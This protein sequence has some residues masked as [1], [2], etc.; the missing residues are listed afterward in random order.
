[1]KRIGFLLTFFIV[2]VTT[3]DA[4]TVTLTLREDLSS[5]LPTETAFTAVDTAGKVYN[6]HVVTHPARRL[7]RRGSMIFG[8]R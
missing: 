1:M 7:L 6:G 3:G 2:L 5:K 4:Q 8:V